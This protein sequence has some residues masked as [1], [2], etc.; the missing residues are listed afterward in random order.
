MRSGGLGEDGRGWRE[1][2]TGEDGS[3]GQRDGEGRPDGRLGRGEIGQ[4]E[5][6]GLGEFLMFPCR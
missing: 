6:A 5:P 3:E 1:R 4:H 2:R